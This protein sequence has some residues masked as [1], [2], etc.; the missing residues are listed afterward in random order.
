MRE[1]S[2]SKRA[3]CALAS[4]ASCSAR[5]PIFKSTMPPIHVGIPNATSPAELSLLRSPF[6]GPG[7]AP[8]CVW[9]LSPN[10][11]AL[12][13]RLPCRRSVPF[14]TALR[15]HGANAIVY[16]GHAF[17]VTS[18]CVLPESLMLY[19]VI[20][21]SQQQFTSHRRPSGVGTELIFQ[22]Y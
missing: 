15:F 12:T 18:I 1:R 6:V 7:S 2:C 17:M 11:R 8:G 3:C 10:I 9:P 22:S 14:G 13:T 19:R 5:F 21:C 20:F 16:L 4:P